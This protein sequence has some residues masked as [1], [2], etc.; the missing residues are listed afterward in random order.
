MQLMLSDLLVCYMTMILAE[1]YLSYVLW[2]VYM[3]T[4]TPG[5]TP[6]VRVPSSL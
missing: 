5:P 1:T 6:P 2:K 4:L 3:V